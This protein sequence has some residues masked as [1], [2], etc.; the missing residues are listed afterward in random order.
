MSR[1][2]TKRLAA[3]FL[4]AS[5]VEPAPAEPK[6]DGVIQARIGDHLRLMYDELIHQPVPDRFIELLDRLDT[7]DGETAS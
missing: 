5:T 4:D 3:T 2:K 7:R 6:L 1:E